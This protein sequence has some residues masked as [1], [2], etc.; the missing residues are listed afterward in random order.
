MTDTLQPVFGIEKVYVKDC[1]LEVPHAPKIFL[2]REE[3]ELELSVVTEH[4]LIGK[5]Y[6]EVT[7]R[8]TVTATQPSDE[9]TIFVSEATQAGIFIIQNMPEDDLEIILNV[10][11]PNMIFPYLRH[12]I[13]VLTS[14]AGFPSVNLAPYNF[15]AEY[16]KRKAQPQSGGLQ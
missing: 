3:P 1:S 6:Y 7:V 13:F 14:S 5:D 11:A 16:R 10:A 8:A 2:S 15:E 9:K 4:A 12:T